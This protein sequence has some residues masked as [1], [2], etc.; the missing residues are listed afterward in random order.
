MTF[1]PCPPDVVQELFGQIETWPQ[2][3]PGVCRVRVLERQADY[4]RA[5]LRT[6]LM[7]HELEQT[8]EFR[9][10]GCRFLQRQIA[11]RVKKWDAE[12][13]LLPTP[14]GKG[15]SLSVA[16]DIELGILG[17]FVP[18]RT[19]RNGVNE[20]FGQLARRVEERV[21]CVLAERQPAS[22]TAGCDDRGETLLQVYQCPDGLEVR[23]G[24]QRYYLRTLG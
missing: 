9:R 19:V 13:N 18:Q 1:L 24:G 10:C 23:V 5:E 11:G 12:W 15:T 6:V 17:L 14:D 21:R 3:M 2:W 4:A 7:G 16:L 20:W 22:P 8:V